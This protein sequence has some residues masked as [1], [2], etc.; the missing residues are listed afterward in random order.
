[1]KQIKKAI[2]TFVKG[3]DNNDTELLEKILHPNFQNIQDG[4]FD[5]EGIYVFSKEQYIDLV[6]TKKF[7]GNLRSI[8]YQFIEQMGN[9][10]VAKASLES[11]SLKFSSLIM[12]AYTNGDWQVIN[13]TPTIE[14]K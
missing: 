6:K 2:E 10:A 13:N 1:M 4:F 14:A 5:E 12:L 11:Q 9:I 7:G 3:G 8:E